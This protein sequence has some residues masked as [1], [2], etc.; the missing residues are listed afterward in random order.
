MIT[1]VSSTF[2]KTIKQEID[3]LIARFDKEYTD[4]IQKKEDEI[5]QNLNKLF[6]LQAEI[7]GKI[8]KIS[9][10]IN[11]YIYGRGK[12]D[13]KSFTK[14]NKLNLDL[15]KKLSLISDRMRPFEQFQGKD[16]IKPRSISVLSPAAKQETVS[17]HPLGLHNQGANCAFNSLIQFLSHLPGLKR[18]CSLLP[19]EFDELKS[20]L[21][22]HLEDEMGNRTSSRVDSQRMRALMHH[23]FGTFSLSPYREE[24]A[25]E[26]LMCILGRIQHVSGRPLYEVSPLYSAILSSRR[27]EPTGI[28]HDADPEKIRRTRANPEEMD[29]YSLLDEDNCSRKVDDDCQIIIDLKNRGHLPFETLFHTFFINRGI[30]GSANAQYLGSDDRLHEYRVTEETKEFTFP[31]K[32]MLIALKRFYFDNDGR[33]YKIN[34]PVA[35]PLLLELPADAVSTRQSARY[36]LDGFVQHRGDSADSGHYV[37]FLKINGKWIEYNDSQT[38]VL[39]KD[40]I[41]VALQNPYFLHYRHID[42]S[43]NYPFPVM[44]FGVRAPSTAILDLAKTAAACM[45]INKCTEELKSFLMLFNDE[46][47]P[48]NEQLKNA[49]YNILGDALINDTH[50]LVWLNGGM[51]DIH[52][53]GKK[54]C[55]PN[56]RMLKTINKPYLSLHGSNILE[57]MLH[58]QEEKQ[59]LSH[60]NKSIA[61]LKVFLEMLNDPEVSN[62]EL[63]KA[64]YQFDQK[65][66]GVRI[67]DKFHGLVYRNHPVNED[68]YGQK[69]TDA[70]VRVLLEITKPL[71]SLNGGNL[72]EQMV[73][74][75]QTQANK[76]QFAFQK[77][78]LEAFY[79]LL[80]DPSISNAQLQKVF[81]NLDNDLIEKLKLSVWIAD[82]QKDILKYGEQTI[83][84]DARCLL[85]IDEPLLSSS[86]G[87]IVTQL[88]SLLD[89]E[90][91]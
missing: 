33:R 86:G 44:P 40:Q 57:Q 30:A 41:K 51:K 74:Y 48:D 46:P 50:Y 63:K 70:N 7:E 64:F 28:S 67:C 81:N 84:S 43:Q 87:D 18:T 80:K 61:Q 21:G 71:L 34:S 24:D 62:D 66:D 78:Q 27:Y 22:M 91:K 13:K 76:A 15:S 23:L 85:R 11:C 54:E 49:F 16:Q 31:P 79:Q 45:D 14:I 58:V 6:K 20:L 47:I 4:A 36:E 55:D 77:G 8:Q 32:E 26:A 73:H 72:V 17:Y 19:S 59:V 75:V 53:Y 88:I 38:R 9:Y 52:E 5:G 25:Y 69:K 82:G 39:T 68:C 42:L 90:C 2:S 65:I 60:L 89:Q 29:T 56:I 37:A 1:T 12:K 10:S 83:A 35:V 3:P